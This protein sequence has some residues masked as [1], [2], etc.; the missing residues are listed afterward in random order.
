MRNP[1]A[2][3][4]MKRDTGVCMQVIPLSDH[5]PDGHPDMCS[6]AELGRSNF[7]VQRY[8]G[9]LLL[10]TRVLKTGSSCLQQSQEQKTNFD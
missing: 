3:R 10:R 7:Q 1:V 8:L 4:D 2:R 9:P 6:D 5:P